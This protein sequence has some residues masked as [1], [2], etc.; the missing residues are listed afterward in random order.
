MSYLRSKR[1][2]VLLAMVA[3]AFLLSVGVGHADTLLC[4]LSANQNTAVGG[5]YTNVSGLIGNP[6]NTSIH[7]A[8]Q[9]YIPTDTDYARL[10]WQGTGLTLGSIGNTNATVAFT[11]DNSGDQPYYMMTFQ[12][13]ANILGETNPGDQI[14]M[15]QFQSTPS[16]SGSNMAL[17][18]NGTQFNMFDNTSGVYLQGGQSTTNS[19]NGWLTLF[20]LLT[21]DAITGFRIGEGL[22]GAC[23][24]PCSET[25]TIYSVDV[26]SSNAIPEPAS[27]LL[28]GSALFLGLGLVRHQRKAR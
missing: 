8:V 11:A 21:S 20:P 22:A 24:G 19:L 15:L 2:L 3:A 17:D 6:C 4:P 23:S 13:P 7:P 16:V 10:E 5:I 12:D 1:F 27:L 9:M 26:G 25:L 14:L 28:V 18:P